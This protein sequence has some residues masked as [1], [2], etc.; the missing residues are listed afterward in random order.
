M[1]K[2]LKSP[3]TPRSTRSDRRKTL[4]EIAKSFKFGQSPDPKEEERRVKIRKLIQVCC[5]CKEKKIGWDSTYAEID[6]DKTVGAVFQA[7][8]VRKTTFHSYKNQATAGGGVD[9]MRIN[10]KRGPLKTISSNAMKIQAADIVH[11]KLRGEYSKSLLQVTKAAMAATNEERR[12]PVK[13]IPKVPS[14]YLLRSVEKDCR[15]ERIAF[16]NV[17]EI[18]GGK[19]KEDQDVR[20]PVMLVL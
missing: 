9:A 17:T 7:L 5:E 3:V 18:A 19:L 11:S 1:S 12:T 2:R 4:E 15:R 16:T 10:F 13:G 20:N 6:P 14:E 8:S